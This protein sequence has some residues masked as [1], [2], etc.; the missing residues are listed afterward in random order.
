MYCVSCNVR[1]CK[2]TTKFYGKCRNKCCSCFHVHT[3]TVTASYR[4]SKLNKYQK[5]Y[6]LINERIYTQIKVVQDTQLQK[7]TLYCQVLL[8]LLVLD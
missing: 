4:T 3:Y 5:N 6:I 2:T 8:Q 1:K 7:Y